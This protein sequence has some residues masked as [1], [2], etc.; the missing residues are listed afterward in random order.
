MSEVLTNDDSAAWLKAMSDLE[1]DCELDAEINR[2]ERVL[3]LR[4]ALL[5]V[6]ARLR[7]V[8]REL[9]AIEAQR[10]SLRG[11]MAEVLAER[12]EA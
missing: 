7:D 10:G 3:A 5:E 6:E 9:C 2:A 8:H 4:N 1:H 12:C 11:Q